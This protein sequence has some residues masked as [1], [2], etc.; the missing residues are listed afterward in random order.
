MNYSEISKLVGVSQAHI[1]MC[2]SGKRFPSWQLAKRISAIVDIPPE[3]IIENPTILQQFSQW[4][5]SNGK[6][7]YKA[8]S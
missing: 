3:I 8:V 1:S 2:A 4:N 6:R 7:I 5:R